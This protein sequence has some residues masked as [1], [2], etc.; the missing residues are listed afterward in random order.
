LALQ[1]VRMA[2]SLYLGY[3]KLLLFWR[4]S[5]NYQEYLCF[6][7]KMQNETWKSVDHLGWNKCAR[8]L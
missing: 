6:K 7:N 8:D 3:Y 4:S 5:R 1:E 2:R